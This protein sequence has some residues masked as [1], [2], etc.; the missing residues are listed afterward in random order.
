[1]IYDRMAPLDD[2]AMLAYALGSLEHFGDLLA[3]YA[4]AAESAHDAEVLAEVRADNDR[5]IA[6]LRGMEC[7]ARYAEAFT[8]G[9]AMLTW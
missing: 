8:T 5:A 4:D 2:E 6:R 9:K 3:V 7:R 1:M